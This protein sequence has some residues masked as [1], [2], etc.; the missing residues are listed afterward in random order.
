MSRRVPKARITAWPPTPPFFT[1]CLDVI[2]ANPALLSRL[3]RPP[4]DTLRCRTEAEC[5]WVIRRELIRHGRRRAGLDWLQRSVRALPS[6]RRLLLLTAAQALPL[7]P[8]S[9]RGP[10]GCYPAR[11]EDPLLAKARCIASAP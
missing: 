6:A 2:F 9:L 5:H 11:A 10:F 3:G 1:A 4:L 7:Q 8:T